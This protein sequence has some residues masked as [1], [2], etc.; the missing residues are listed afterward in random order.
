MK[1]LVLLALVACTPAA[2]D[3]EPVPVTTPATPETACAKL[4]EL[5]CPESKPTAT[6]TCPDLFRL[7]TRLQ[8]MRVDCIT[9]ADSITAVRACRTVRCRD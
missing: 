1:A 8:D 9:A 6:V 7:A 2:L 5:G 3:P 4:G